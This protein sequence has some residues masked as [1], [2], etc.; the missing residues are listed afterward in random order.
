MQR[1]TTESPTI[2]NARLNMIKLGVSVTTSPRPARS[3]ILNGKI[4]E[5]AIFQVKSAHR[6]VDILSTSE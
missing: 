1:P 4:N 6:F 5:A 3:K 2:V